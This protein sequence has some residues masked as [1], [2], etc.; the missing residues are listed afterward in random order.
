MVM[1]TVLM[2][3]DSPSLAAV[4][5]GYLRDEKVEVTAVDSGSKALEF[6]HKNEPDVVWCC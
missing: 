4:Y 6:L 5:Q 3:E 1:N 2:V